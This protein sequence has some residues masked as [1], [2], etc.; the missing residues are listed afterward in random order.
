MIIL[1][2]VEKVFHKIQRSFRSFGT[3]NSQQR[4]N[5]EESPHSNVIHIS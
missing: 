5:E 3:K 1:T 2:D 4:R